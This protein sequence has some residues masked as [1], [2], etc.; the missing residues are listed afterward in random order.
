M[1]RGAVILLLGVIAA[2]TAYCA[3]YFGK[4]REE[5]QLLE[6]PAPELAWLKKEFRLSDA[7]F[8]RVAKLHDGYLPRCEDLCRQIAQK[9][10]ELK[11]LVAAG[12]VNAAAVQDKLK[13][14]GALRVQC[15]MNMFNH[16]LEVSRQMPPEQGKRYLQ[17]VQQQTLTPE[18]SMEQRHA[19]ESAAVQRPAG[20]HHH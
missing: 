19:E 2:I 11:Q 17:W 12:D 13:E 7:E 10:G 15:Q 5:R 3:L 8:E 4:T 1:R 6:A 14:V 16:F 9:N 20:P 18:H